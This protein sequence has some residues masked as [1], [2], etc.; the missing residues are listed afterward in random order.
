MPETSVY[1]ADAEVSNFMGFHVRP[2]QRF[3]AMA[4]L[5]QADVELTV[6]D[7]T[8]PGASLMHLMSLG[9]TQGD[10]LHIVASGDDGRQCRDALVFMTENRFFVEDH[11]DISQDDQRHLK[12]LAGLASCFLSDVSAQIG[13]ASVDA[14]DACALQ[15]AGITPQSDVAF[16]A[17][18]PDAEQALRV[19]EHLA[20]NCYYVEDQMGK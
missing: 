5:F 10:V 11:Q 7:R 15:K 14:K 18:G 8:A 4:R 6:R 20:Q 13:D 3:A 2:V 17:H 9:A 1:T 19:L 12:R 16:A